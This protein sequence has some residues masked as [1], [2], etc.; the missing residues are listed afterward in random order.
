MGERDEQRKQQ[1][2]RG[3]QGGRFAGKSKDKVVGMALKMV[4]HVFIVNINSIGSV[5]RQT[6]SSHLPCA[7]LTK[8]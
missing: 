2:P 5:V 4:Q 7:Y 8:K 3:R 1:I 6:G